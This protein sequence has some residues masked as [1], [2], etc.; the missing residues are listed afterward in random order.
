MN[1]QCNCLASADDDGHP[2]HSDR[3]T[4]VLLTGADLL[5]WSEKLVLSFQVLQI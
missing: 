4:V 3:G 5:P 1:D 2:S